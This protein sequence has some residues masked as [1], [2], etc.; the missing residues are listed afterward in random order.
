MDELTADEIKNGW[1]PASLKAYLKEREQAAEE[2]IDITNR[3]T[4]PMEQTRYRP[5]RWRE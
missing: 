4:R 2:K 3:K 1:T 5:L